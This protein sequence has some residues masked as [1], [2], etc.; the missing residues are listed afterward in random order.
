MHL[1]PV[2]GHESRIDKNCQSGNKKE[3][4]L[5]RCS[6]EPNNACFCLLIQ[7]SEGADASADRDRTNRLHA[8]NSVFKRTER[9]HAGR[10]L[11]DG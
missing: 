10:A 1:G 3:Q 7:R 2:T 11:V 5:A 9:A 8:H 4:R 6:L